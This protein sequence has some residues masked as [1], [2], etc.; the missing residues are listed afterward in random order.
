[1]PEKMV[2]K[3]I[4]SKLIVLTIKLI[5]LHSDVVRL[6]STL[7]AWQA[8]NDEVISGLYMDSAGDKKAGTGVFDG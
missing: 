6:V 2:G 1:M 5:S 8:G 7:E 4:K 3:S